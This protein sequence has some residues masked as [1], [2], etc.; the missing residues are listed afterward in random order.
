MPFLACSSRANVSATYNTLADDHEDST[1]AVCTFASNYS[2][3]N[4]RSDVI[5]WRDTFDFYC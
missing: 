3:P 1:L 5:T 4:V 2:L